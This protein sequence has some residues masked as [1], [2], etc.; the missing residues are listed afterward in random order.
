MTNLPDDCQRL[1]E[2]ARDGHDP[3]DPSAR[4]RVRHAVAASL[5]LSAAAGGSIAP[6]ALPATHAGASNSQVLSSA[7]HTTLSGKTGLA[8][9]MSKLGAVA[10]AAVAAAGIG[11]A[12]YRTQQPAPRVQLPNP[13][14]AAP[15]ASAP[16][17]TG[18]PVAHEVERQ[19]LTPDAVSRTASADSAAEAAALGREA[20]GV[21]QSPLSTRRKQR[22]STLSGETALLRTASE[23][24]ARGD[25]SAALDA[26]GLHAR[27][28]PQGSLRE[29]RDGLRAIAECTRDTTPSA[30]SAKR[31]ARAYPHSMLSARVAKAC[32]DK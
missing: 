6:S 28:F 11:Y 22:A 2:L 26:L 1:L 27:Q 18:E 7:A 4:L 3:V 16:E 31:F 29:E 20:A 13:S 8:V 30:A 19:Q 10:T 24:I 5:A 9:F 15:E 12:V 17:T 21:A 25:E 23:A 14:V 32:A